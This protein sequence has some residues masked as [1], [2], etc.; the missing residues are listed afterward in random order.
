MSRQERVGVIGA[1]ALGLMA[2]KEFLQEGFDVIAFETRPYVGGLWKDTDDDTLSV[3]PK[4]IFNTS[5]FRAAISSFPFPEDV[6]VYPTAAQFH[7]Y[8]ESYADHFDLRR[9]IH[10]RHRVKQVLWLQDH[11][12]L[13]VEDLATGEVDSHHFDRVCVATGSFRDPRRPKM[14]GIEKFQGKVLHSIDF[15]SSAPFKGDNVLVI[16]IHATAQDVTSILSESAKHVYLSHRQGQVLL[17]RFTK[18]GAAFDT[19][20]GMGVVM[21]QSWCESNL[22]SLWNWVMDKT[23]DSVSRAA[24]P[25]MPESWG[26][27]PAT[28]LAVSTPLM[29]DV[30]YPFLESGFAEPVPAVREI[31]GPKTVALTNG[32]V[33]DDID[34]ILFCTGY[35]ATIP[36]DVIPKSKD[37]NSQVITS[38]PPHPNGTDENPHLYMNMFPLAPDDNIRNSFAIVGQAA[39]IWPGLTQAE[40]QIMAIAQVWKGRK[41]LPSY[42][43][44]LRWYE[45]HTRAREATMKRHNVL[46]S[47]TFYSAL[48]PFAEIF[49]WLN[50]MAGTGLYETFGGKFNGIFNPRAWSL[51]W[52]D[53]EIYD[54]CTKGYFNPVIF[55]LVDLGGRPALSREEVRTILKKGKDTLERAVKQKREDLGL[56]YKQYTDGS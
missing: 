1:G 8:L 7:K 55:R 40:L 35:N 38:Y 43:E 26:L 56:A 13:Q 45:R 25:D 53:R 27:R 3:G 49:P 16:G 42:A 41:S 15:H 24:Y 23:V 11:W 52:N 34:T 37:I 54:L 14:E 51:W 48:V 12:E 36:P 39:F 46:S 20:M 9:H 17:P 5:K 44:M 10:T 6:G 19:T 2:V 18:D 30:L 31:T 29:A 21:F 33:L 32:R 50:H 4:T 22:P 28:S 47:G